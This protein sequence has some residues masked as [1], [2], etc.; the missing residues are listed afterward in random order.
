MVW[1]RFHGTTWEFRA[2]AII[3]PQRRRRRFRV[4]LQATHQWICLQNSEKQL[5]PCVCICDIKLNIFGS[6]SQIH[7]WE[8]DNI[9][10]RV[11]YCTKWVSTCMWWWKE[12]VTRDV[13]TVSF[14]HTLYA[15]FFVAI[16]QKLFI[17]YK[18]LMKKIK[19]YDAVL[20]F[21]DFSART[22]T[23]GYFIK[24]TLMISCS[25]GATLTRSHASPKCL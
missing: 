11:L 22:W 3:S 14:K 21:A 23:A 12:S 20:Y 19:R 16:L 18:C 13:H 6:D 15:N 1:Q 4:D 2:L 9:S 10:E 25:W 17:L 8:R 5:L 24:I 7:C